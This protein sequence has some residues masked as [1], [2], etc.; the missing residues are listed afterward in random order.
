MLSYNMIGHR[1]TQLFILD[2][3]EYGIADYVGLFTDSE[4]EIE[5]HANTMF[6]ALGG[7]WVEISAE[8]SWALIASADRITEEYGAEFPEDYLQFR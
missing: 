4:E 6:G 8:E 2:Y 3:E 7:E 5:A 1:F